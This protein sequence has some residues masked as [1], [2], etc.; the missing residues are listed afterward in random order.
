[1]RSEIDSA[2]N[3]RSSGTPDEPHSHPHPRQEEVL[4]SLEAQP[5]GKREDEHTPAW[6]KKSAKFTKEQMKKKHAQHMHY[7]RCLGA[8]IKVKKHQ[9]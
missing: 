9:T 7:H 2:E 6:A 8:T 1:M 5:K 4:V 3:M